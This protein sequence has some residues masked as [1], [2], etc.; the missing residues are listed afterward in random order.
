LSAI[1]GLYED[2]LYLSS[3]YEYLAEPVVADTGH[4]TIGVLPGDGLAFRKRLFPLSLASSRA[5]LEG[6]DLHLVP[7]RSL[8]LVGENGSGKTTL[9]KLL[10]RLYPTRPR[11]EFCWTAVTCRIGNSR[12]C[13]GA[14]A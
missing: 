13:D 7:G 1:S 3:L 4:L 14:S 8:A 10:T 5:A 12:T 9:I 11:A 2:G 6:I